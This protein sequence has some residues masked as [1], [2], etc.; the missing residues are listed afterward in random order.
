[1]T[2]IVIVVTRIRLCDTAQPRI[3]VL[4]C[5]PGPVVPPAAKTVREINPPVRDFYPP[6]N[7]HTLILAPENIFVFLNFIDSFHKC[8]S[9]RLDQSIFDCRW[10]IFDVRC[11][12][13]AIDHRTSTIDHHFPRPGR[14]AR[15]GGNNYKKDTLNGNRLS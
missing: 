1:M 2:G 7:L 15:S 9:P 10:S 14:C 11:I 6:E 3:F 8:S 12:K 5:K 4:L 13:S